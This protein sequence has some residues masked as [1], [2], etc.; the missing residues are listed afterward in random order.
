MTV[1]L[2]LCC[3]YFCHTLSQSNYNTCFFSLS[4][5][6]VQQYYL[7]VDHFYIALLSRLT[8]LLLHVILNEWLPF[9]SAFWISTKVLCIVWL[10]VHMLHGWCH[11]K[12]LPS[13]HIM[14]TPYNDALCPVTPSKATNIGCMH[15]G[16]NWPPSLL[17]EWLG[18]FMCHRGNTGWSRY[19]NKSQ[20]R[21]LTLERKI[22]LPLLPWLKPLTFQ[23]QVS[24]CN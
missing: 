22:L 12:L 23:S 15:V 20:R 5:F 8:M 13:R 14:W 21:K 1:L 17:S 2:L 6:H 19:Q 4:C 11:M 9:Y 10:L 3:L 16:Y 18:S 24:R 7:F